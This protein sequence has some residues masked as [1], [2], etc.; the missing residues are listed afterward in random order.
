MKKRSERMKR[1]E[2]M[3]NKSGSAETKPEETP[4][5]NMEIEERTQKKKKEMNRA[6]SSPAQVVKD[7]DSSQKVSPNRKAEKKRKIEETNN[8][9]LVPVKKSKK[10][11]SSS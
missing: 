8:V 2:Q 9:P 6:V 4:T 3:I 11:K 1:F 10:E 5:D 7:A